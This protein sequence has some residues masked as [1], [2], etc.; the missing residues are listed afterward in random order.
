MSL[1][2]NTQHFELAAKLLSALSL[3]V[4][5]VHKARS[6]NGPVGHA[7]VIPAVSKLRSRQQQSTCRPVVCFFRLQVDAASVGIEFDWIVIMKPFFMIG[8]SIEGRVVN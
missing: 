2:L 4:Q 5:H 7:R 3:T 1:D 6:R 8:C